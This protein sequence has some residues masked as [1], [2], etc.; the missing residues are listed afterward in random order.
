MGVGLFVSF[1][2]RSDLADAS[3]FSDVTC[4]HLTST[5]QAPAFAAV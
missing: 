3:V 5:A 2:S 4:S 1:S